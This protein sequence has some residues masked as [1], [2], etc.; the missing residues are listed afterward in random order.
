MCDDRSPAKIERDSNILL[1]AA[2]VTIA[3]LGLLV[4]KVILTVLP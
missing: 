1:A 2:I 4:L 3:C